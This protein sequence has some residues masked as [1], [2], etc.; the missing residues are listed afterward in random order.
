VARAPA[1][2]GQVDAPRER[3]FDHGPNLGEADAT[4]IRP[5]GERHEV[6]CE[7]VATDVGRLPDPAVLDLL[8]NGGV[9]GT[10]ILCAAAIVLPVRADE[11]ERMPDRRPYGLDVEPDQVVVPVELE[12]A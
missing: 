10:P 3:G 2:A 9:E 6:A 7:A 8:S 12:P 4:V 1:I 5:V 11:K